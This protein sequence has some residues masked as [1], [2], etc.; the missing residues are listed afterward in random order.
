MRTQPQKSHE[1]SKEEKPPGIPLTGS[2]LFITL[3]MF[4]NAFGEKPLLAHPDLR[5]YSFYYVPELRFWEWAIALQI[6]V[7]VAADCE[8]DDER[9]LRLKQHLRELLGPCKHETLVYIRNIPFVI[10]RP[11]MP[12]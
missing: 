4:I 9:V 5:L 6:V 11:P 12:F 7:D 3:R 10:E 1:Y 8:S 2:D